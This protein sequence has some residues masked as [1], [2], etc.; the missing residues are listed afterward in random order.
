M[1]VLGEIVRAGE[2]KNER[3]IKRRRKRESKTL[4]PFCFW[5]VTCLCVLRSLADSLSVRLKGL[6]SS[7]YLESR[8]K[9]V[10]SSGSTSQDSIDSKIPILSTLS[11]TTV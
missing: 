10:W 6:H 11:L 9:P 3:G 5:L 4:A 1:G 7:L 2:K 8:P